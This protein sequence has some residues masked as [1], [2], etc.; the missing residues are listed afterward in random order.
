MKKINAFSII[1]A[2]ILLILSQ[3]AFSKSS[4]GISFVRKNEPRER[5]FSLWCHAGGEWRAEPSA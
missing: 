4:G 3:A 1:S 2:L 5:A